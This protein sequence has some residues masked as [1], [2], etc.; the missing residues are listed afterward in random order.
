MDIEMWKAQVESGSIE[1]KREAIRVAGSLP[2]TDIID[3]LISIL[4][5]DNKALQEAVI[6]LLV[7]RP[8]KL[9][10]EKL[11]PLLREENANVRNAAIE[12]LEKIGRDYVDL[13]GAYLED[14]DKDVRLFVCDIIGKFGTEKALEYL[15]KALYDEEI[16]VRNSAVM[17]IGSIVNEKSVSVLAELLER[18]TDTWV[19]F[20]IID[21]LTKIG[22]DSAKEVLRKALYREKNDVV[23]KA[24]LDGI[25][26][27]GDD[28]FIYDIMY[29]FE[30]MSSQKL[31]DVYSDII[32]FGLRVETIPDDEAVRKKF[33]VYLLAYIKYSDDR[34]NAYR[35]VNI[36]SKL[37]PEAEWVLLDILQ[38]ISEPMIINSAIEGLREIGTA[39]ALDLLAKFVDSEDENQANL[40]REAIEKIKERTNA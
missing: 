16:N 39:K 28:I 32:D 30:F 7:S 36:V 18:E 14:E 37:G 34:W 19:R 26:K 35:A 23:L 15:S 9:V 11:M 24:L 10:V 1:E 33:A 31:S 3:T 20:S 21:A 29:V 13:I 6:E 40:T 8:D 5:V 38:T 12:V 25:S 27:F 17:G 22:L 2:I 4:Y